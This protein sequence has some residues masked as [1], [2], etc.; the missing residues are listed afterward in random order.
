MHQT[1]DLSFRPRSPQFAPYVELQQFL[2]S[3]ISNISPFVDQLMLFL[4]QLIHEFRYEAGREPDIEIALREAVANAVI[5]GNRENPEKRVHVTCRCRIDGEVL[6][7]VRDE[8]QGFDICAISDTTD[9]TNLLL[10]HGRGIQLMRALM[11]EVTFD[12]S[13]TVVRLRKRLGLSAE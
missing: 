10:T 13:G 8:G 1:Q 5:H 9:R 3:R 6:L 2:M 11:D 4:K 12:E 7:T